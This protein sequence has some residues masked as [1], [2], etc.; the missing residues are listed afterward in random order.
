MSDLTTFDWDKFYTLQSENRIDRALDLIFE[1]CDTSGLMPD[2]APIDALLAAVDLKHIT[3]VD[4][5]IGF[6]SAPFPMSHHLSSYKPLLA[7]VRDWLERRGEK[8]RRIN[9]LLQGF[10]HHPLEQLI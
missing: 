1:A 9:K 2:L 8:K 6:L 7:K 5:A 4:L 10:E 3:S